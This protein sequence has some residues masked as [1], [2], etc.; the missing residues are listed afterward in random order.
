MAQPVGTVTIAHAPGARTGPAPARHRPAY[1]LWAA[2]ALG[3]LAQSLAGTAGALLARQLGGSDAVAGLPQALLV[4]GAAVSALGLSALTRHRGRGVALSV[5]AVVAMAGAIVVVVAGLSSSLPGVLVGSLLLGSGNTAVML[6]RYAAADL[7]PEASRVRSMA[8]VLVATTLG[9]VVGPNL[10]APAGALAAGIGMPVLVGPYLVATVGFAAAGVALAAGLGI[11]RNSPVTGVAG[12]RRD[13]IGVAG[14]PLGRPGTVGLAILGVANL[15][16]VSVMAMAPVHLH[17]AGVGLG[18]IGLVVSV[19]IAGMFA[20]A[21][22]SS[23]LTDR[24]G[25]V[26]AAAASGAVLAAACALTA[27]GATSL[28]LLVAGLVLL[29]IGWNLALVA[30]SV[31]ITAGVPVLQRPR[32][33][34]WGEVSMGAAAA[35]GGVVSGLVVTAGGY[36]T[37]AAAAAIVALLLPC[38]WL[39]R[40]P[41]SSAD[42][43]EDDR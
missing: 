41:R 24:I 12:G 17:H 19:H 22:L 13:P 35:S 29:G 16:M 38:A 20:P 33:E 40:G 14:T 18:G 32:R 43:A 4:A 10:L 39:E 31:L 9:A 3:G 25:A 15:V 8:A 42:P 1:A 36:P 6:G 21:P 37:L 34:G 28:A 5:G 23:W 27:A 11:E 30:G 2:C 26:P 7:G